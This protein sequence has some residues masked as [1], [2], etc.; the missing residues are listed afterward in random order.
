M[1]ELNV[2]MY[3]FSIAWSRILPSG[4]IDRKNEKG[5]EYYSNL[6]DELL[7]FNIT[8]IVTLYHWDLPQRLQEL[9]GWTN[10]LIVGYFRDYAELVFAQFSDRVQE[11]MMMV[12][13][14]LPQ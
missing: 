11:I 9:G 2:T 12:T 7:R 6:I 3:R 14:K 8:P 10:E 4:R 13:E 5:L 1:R